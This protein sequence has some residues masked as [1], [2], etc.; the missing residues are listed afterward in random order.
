MG[1]TCA[2]CHSTVDDAF[3]P[4][5]GRRL[6]GWPNR[7]LNVG[8]IVLAAPNLQPILDLLQ[9]DAATAKSVLE[10]WGPGKYDA[11]LNL[12]GKGFRPDGKTAAVLIPAAYGKARRER[13]HVGHGLGQHHVLERLRRQPPD[14]RPGQRS[15]TRGSTTRRSTPWPRARN[16]ATRATNDDRVTKHLA[17]LHFYQLALPAPTPPPGQLRRAGR[18]ARQ[19]GL[20][21]PGEVRD[22]PRAAAVHRTRLERAH[23][24]GGGRRRLPREPRARPAGTARRRSP[25]SSRGRRAAS[26]T[27]GASRRSRTSSSTTTR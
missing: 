12:D 8:K 18:A 17:A 7:D 9:I 16:W 13:A 1:I 19:A 15:T 14:A 26:T 27:T 5:I 11:E 22:V 25:G 4:G 6:D 20:R 23:R 21:R 2:I 24:R 10:A 3:A